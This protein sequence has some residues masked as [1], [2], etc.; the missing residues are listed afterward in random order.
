[1][2][3]SSFQ[4]AI[5]SRATRAPLGN[6]QADILIATLTAYLFPQ[7]LQQTPLQNQPLQVPLLASMADSTLGSP[8]ISTANEI[9]FI[10]ISYSS[11]YDLL[12]FEH[13]SY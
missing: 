9:S 7:S 12:P 8:A 11:T 6:V 1:M 13:Y 3:P 5:T 10:S 4:S 2:G